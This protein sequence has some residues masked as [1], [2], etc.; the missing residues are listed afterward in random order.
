MTSVLALVPFAEQGRIGVS[1]A[2][3]PITAKSMMVW[4][5]GFSRQSARSSEPQNQFAALEQGAFPPAKAGTPNRMRVRVFIIFRRWFP[6]GFVPRET[7]F[8]DVRDPTKGR[9]DR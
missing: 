6:R 8:G 1:A 7:S 5:P 4:S 2:T 9:S 3:P